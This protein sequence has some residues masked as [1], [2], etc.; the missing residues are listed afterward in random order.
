ME[1]DREPG[2]RPTAP[3]STRSEAP[4]P[5]AGNGTV[6]VEPPHLADESHWYTEHTALLI[7]TVKWSLLGA[8]TGLCVGEGTR[9]FLWS[10]AA[11]SRLVAG[12]LSGLVRPYYL[13]PVALPACVWLIRTFAPTAKGHGTEAVITAVHQRSGRVE[14]KVAPI[15]LLATVLTLAF[16]GSVGKEGPCAQIGAAITSLFADLLHLRDEDRRRLVICGI[17]AGF[18]AVFGTPVSGALFGIEVL[19]L[20]RIEYSVLFPC[21]VA[22][23][24]AHLTCGVRPPFPALQA[25]FADT[26]Q[27]RTILIMLPCGALFGLIALLLIES[28]RFFERTLRRFER[29]P[30]LL[31]G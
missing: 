25:A 9:A 5:T 16:G 8:A 28:L 4:Q 22:G 29:R 27:V 31:S 3:V 30:Y 14:W 15:K 13:L 17:G 12:G 26:R 18:A 19:Y 21:L 20:G 1:L 24:V 11:S 7:S 23:I 2:M 6:D 10:L